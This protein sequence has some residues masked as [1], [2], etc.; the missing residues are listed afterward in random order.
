MVAKSNY[1]LS[2]FYPSVLPFQVSDVIPDLKPTTADLARWVSQHLP[3]TLLSS[4]T[5][6]LLSLALSLLFVD[7]DANARMLHR[8]LPSLSNLCCRRD[9][10]L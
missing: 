8:C 5:L 1:P 4:S 3:L 2:L 6:S 7:E 10:F 9:I